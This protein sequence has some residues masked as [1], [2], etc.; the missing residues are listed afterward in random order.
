MA[1][2]RSTLNRGEV[3]RQNGFIRVEDVIGV[4]NPSYDE[5]NIAVETAELYAGIGGWGTVVLVSGVPRAVQDIGN[6]EKASRK[7]I[8]ERLAQIQ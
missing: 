1:K 5:D 6:Y 4:R 2:Q 7:M 8:Q 3:A